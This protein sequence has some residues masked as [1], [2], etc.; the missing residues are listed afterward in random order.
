MPNSPDIHSEEFLRELMQRQLRLSVL[1][2]TIFGVLLICLPLANY[3][4]PE[5]MGHRFWGFPLNWLILGVLFFPFVWVLSWIFIKRSTDLE[6]E[7]SR[8]V[9]KEL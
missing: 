8:R 2:G 1:I 5:L 7:E 4:F 9:R 6:T 3:F